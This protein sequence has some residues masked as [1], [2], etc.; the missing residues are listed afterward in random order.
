MKSAI[1]N[2]NLKNYAQLASR[3]C[4]GIT[5]L[6]ICD[7]AGALLDATDDHIKGLVEQLLAQCRESDSPT[8]QLREIGRAHV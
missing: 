7:E 1:S 8:G 6:A 2:L 3:M 5:G 4:T